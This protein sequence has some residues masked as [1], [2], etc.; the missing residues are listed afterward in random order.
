MIRN[1]RISEYLR[2]NVKGKPGK[3]K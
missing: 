1:K 3:V 2:I